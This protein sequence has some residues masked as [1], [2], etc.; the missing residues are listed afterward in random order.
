MMKSDLLSTMV[1]ITYQGRNL[2]GRKG[3][4]LFLIVQWMKSCCMKKKVS[5]EKKAPKNVESDLDDNELYQI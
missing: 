2:A 4:M 3:I 1:T 5:S